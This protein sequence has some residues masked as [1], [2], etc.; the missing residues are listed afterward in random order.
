MLPFP[1]RFEY[2]K[3]KDNVMADAL[4][5][6]PVAASVTIVRSLLGGLL[7]LMAIAAIIDE[8]YLAWREEAMTDG[9]HVKGRLVREREGQ[10]WVPRS[11][12]IR[13]FLLSQAH[14]PPWAGYFGEARTFK[15]S[16]EK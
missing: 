4:S 14:D 11:E 3:G 2:V 15:N 1:L 9:R 16:E 10:I 13:T 6:Q 8:E 5:R 12:E 7:Q